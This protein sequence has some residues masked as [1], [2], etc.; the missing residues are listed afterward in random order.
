MTVQEFRKNEKA[1]DVLHTLVAYYMNEINNCENENDFNQCI[2]NFY[3]ESSS[4][5]IDFKLGFKMVELL[6]RRITEE[7]IVLSEL[8]YANKQA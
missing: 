5:I 1:I 6:S 3:K 4:V 2:N 7:I 8:Y